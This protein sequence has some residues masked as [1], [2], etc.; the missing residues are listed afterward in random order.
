MP[1]RNTQQEGM[2]SRIWR[3]LAAC[4]ILCAGWMTVL[5]KGEG[6]SPAQSPKP[7]QRAARQTSDCPQYQGYLQYPLPRAISIDGNRMVLGGS[8]DLM[9]I[10]D[11]TDPRDPKMLSICSLQESY[12]DVILSGQF[13]YAVCMDS[14]RI[15]DISNPASPRETGIARLPEPAY[16]LT[17][18]GRYA[19]VA[20]GSSGLRIIDIANPA[21]PVETGSCTFDGSAVKVHVAG[22][23]AYVA[24]GS[25]GLRIIDVSDPRR[26]S[27]VGSCATNGYPCQ[28][29]YANGYVYVA[30][31]T[32]GLLVIQAANPSLPVLAGSYETSGIAGSVAISGGYAVLG[33]SSNWNQPSQLLSIDLSNPAEPRVIGSCSSPGPISA[34]AIH[35]DTA[36]AGGEFGLQISDFSNPAAPVSLENRFVPLGASALAMADDYAF[37]ADQENRLR[38]VDL[39]DPGSLRETGSCGLGIK[40]RD[41]AIVDDFVYALGMALMIIDVSDPEDPWVTGAA[42]ISNSPIA[43]GAGLA[44]DGRFAYVAAFGEGLKIYNCSSPLSP[45]LAGSCDTPGTASAVA[46]SG[47]YAFVADWTSGLRV[48][49][50]ADPAHPVETGCCLTP[51]LAVDVAVDGRY[52]YLADGVK[53]FRVIDAADPAHPVEIAFLETPVFPQRIALAGQF[54]YLRGANMLLVVDISDPLHPRLAGSSTPGYSTSET[55]AV[56]GPHIAVTGGQGLMLYR[57]CAATFPAAPAGLQAAGTGSGRIQLTWQDN[58]RDE[59]GFFIERREGASPWTR[60][61]DLP[62]GATR[63]TDENLPAGR[64]YTYRVKAFNDPGA[65]APSNEA[66][67]RAPAFDFI[68]PA[69]AHTQGVNGTIWRTDVELLN[70]ETTDTTVE[71]SLLLANQANPAPAVRSVNV[72]AGRAIRLEDV[73]SGLFRAGNAALGLRSGNGSVLVNS[74]F[75]NTASACGGTYG[76]PI[77]GVPP[78]QALPGDGFSAGLFHH[79]AHSADVHSGFR[80]NIGFASASGFPVH[81]RITLFGDSGETIGTAT[82]GLRPYEH[83]QITQ[84]HAVLQTVPVSHGSAAVEVLTPG[85]MVHPYAMVIDN[86]SGDPVYWQPIIISLDSEGLA[87]PERLPGNDY[88]RYIPA[89]AH[90]GGVNQTVWRTDLDLL[91]PWG[92]DA[93]AELILLAA[94]QGNPDPP[95]VQV[96]VPAGQSLRIPDVLGTVFHS[97]NA[98]L[99]VV[100]TAGEAL[101]NARFFNTASACGGTYGMSIESVSDAGALAGDGKSCG[102]LHN[103]KYKPVGQDGFRSNIGFVSASGFPVTVMIQLYGDGGERLAA[104]T[105]TLQPYEHR[106]FTKI[107]ESLRTPSVNDGY[108]A[109]W[110]LTEGGMVHPYAMVIDNVSGDPVYLPMTAARPEQLCRPPALTATLA[111]PGAVRL[112]WNHQLQGVRGF[113]IIRQTGNSPGSFVADLS[114]ESETYTDTGLPDGTACCYRVAAYNSRGVSWSEWKCAVASSNP[115]AAPDRL[116]AS[117]ELKNGQWLVSLAWQDNSL[118]VQGF[119]IERMIRPDGSWQRLATLPA[120]GT[121]WQD[122]AVALGAAYCYRVQAYNTIGVSPFTELCIPVDR[123]EAPAALQAAPLGNGIDLNWQDLAANESSIRIERREGAASGWLTVT[124]AAPGTTRYQDWGLAPGTVY[125][126][127]VRAENIIGASAYSNEASAVPLAWPVRV[128]SGYTPD[129]TRTVVAGGNYACIANGQY[130]MKIVDISNPARPVETAVFPVP[131]DTDGVAIS[132][133][134]AYLAYPVRF[135]ENISR[136]VAVDISDPYHPAEAGTLTFPGFARGVAVSGGYAYVADYNSGLRI[137][138]IADPAHPVLTGSYAMQSRARRIAVNGNYVYLADEEWGLRC[139]NVSNP[140]LPSLASIYP[141]P[142][143]ARAVTIAGRYAYVTGPEEYFNRS[144]LTILDLANPARPQF[145]GACSFEHDS[146]GVAVTGDYAFVTGYSMGLIVVDLADRSQPRIVATVDLPDTMSD[147]TIANGYLYAA[148][149]QNGLQIINLTD[150]LHP[151]PTGRLTSPNDYSGM[152]SS[153]QFAC[154]ADRGSGLYMMDLSEPE[155]PRTA[156][157]CSIPRMACAVEVSGDLAF[158]ADMNHGLSVIGISD[159]AGMN[160]KG[161]MEIPGSTCDLAIGEGIACIANSA[162]L[163][164]ADIA[165]PAHPRE[166]GRFATKESALDVQMAD[167]LVYLIDSGYGLRIIDVSDPARPAE[168]GAYALNNATGVSVAGRYAY[169][170]VYGAGNGVQII[171]VSDPA[172]PR[173]ADFFSLPGNPSRI[174]VSGTTA[175]LIVDNFGLIMMDVTGPDRPKPCAAFTGDRGIHSLA[176]MGGYLL[177]GG[178]SGLNVLDITP[179]PAVPGKQ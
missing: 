82:I 165:D 167:K 79:L 107:H 162:G 23:Y 39:A 114:P 102:I 173:L 64:E 43:M 106:Q 166:I 124:G 101:V 22:Q 11:L 78:V 55:L 172:R 153:G 137:I 84:I 25:F 57:A 16:R 35:E 52:V 53:G 169:L 103:L 149:L 134:Y 126:Y 140:A 14:V 94:N 145:T 80:T 116:R 45:R 68:I 146:C 48:I 111:G 164:V 13:V 65:S 108:A 1:L 71:L 54:A 67:A 58:S 12:Q 87:P 88:A 70:P 33:N 104:T 115:P 144:T 42:G 73:L 8:S 151:R 128:G 20:D 18:S 143:G 112:A 127:R 26:P 110:V 63:Y 77:P 154:V 120:D 117:L 17:V 142:R 93:V 125:T 6:L 135:Q 179:P 96:T 91:N 86:I 9:V 32:A 129:D 72:P 31:G 109:M 29:V 147:L 38:V 60:L 47:D 136:L 155:Q 168:L 5:P 81:V 118:T 163:I 171:D 21:A 74:R 105:I 83:R 10:V 150:P 123:P 66:S 24:D 100:F 138:R 130:G 178:N 170:G 40:I 156:G 44:V 97:G 46:V 2:N 160:V 37:V 19:Y 95:A 69:A 119:H 4:L 61:A 85:G 41:M 177:T 36:Y 133:E 157:F 30:D 175:Y 152:S 59:F 90:T 176:F 139:I 131:G 28:V 161:T 148:C 76:M 62:A 56:A 15:I 99:G 113:R 3:G 158:V 141:L 98:G 122:T 121:N 7:Q 92:T 132:G 51:S 159:P 75:Y 34:V 50:V 27:L 89:A 49:N 174:L